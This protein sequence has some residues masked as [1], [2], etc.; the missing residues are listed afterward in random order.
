MEGSN[1]PVTSRE[2]KLM[3]NVHRFM[4]RAAGIAAFWE[5]TKFMSEK[6]GGSVVETQNDEKERR[7][8][9]L[10]TRNHTLRR[11][12]MVVRLREDITEPKDSKITLKYR[13]ADRYASAARQPASHVAKAKTK[14]EE[15]ILPPFTS[16]FAHSTSIKVK[17]LPGLGTRD[18]RDFDASDVGR[19][20]ALFSGLDEIGLPAE[21]PLQPVNDFEACEVVR[22]LGKLQFGGKP[23]VN[24]CLSFWYLSDP[25]HELPLVGEFSFDYDA[26]KGDGEKNALEQF[27]AGVVEGA[28]RFFR[29]MQRQRN[30]MTFGGTTKTAFAYEGF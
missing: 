12:R 4:D 25:E 8:W 16:K 28:S 23:T 20:G 24:L 1:R 17:H 9:Y 5:L 10:D 15:D 3:L 22:W 27:P 21:T 30:W 6:H 7:T 11:N 14:F 26:P 18:I 29:S 2:Y 19:V 13:S